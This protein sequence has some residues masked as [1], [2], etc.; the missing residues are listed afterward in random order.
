MPESENKR[1]IFQN[2]LSASVRSRKPDAERRGLIKSVFLIVHYEKST[3]GS[4]KIKAGIQNPVL[5]S[6]NPVLNSVVETLAEEIFIKNSDSGG[7]LP[8][9]RHV[10]ILCRRCSAGV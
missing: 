6:Q 9:F 8:I 5:N 1:K 4:E 2:P 3:P 10:A 7:A